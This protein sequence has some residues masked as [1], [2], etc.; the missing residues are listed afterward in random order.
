VVVGLRSKLRNQ[1]S[2]V[3][4]PVVSRGFFNENYTCSR[5]MAICIIIINITLCLSD[6]FMFIRYLVSITQVLKDT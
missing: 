4:I 5:V 6:T 3:Q 2:L 1:R